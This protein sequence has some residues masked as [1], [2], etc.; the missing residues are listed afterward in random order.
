[1]AEQYVISLNMQ[2]NVAEEMAK[3][4]AQF[5]SFQTEFAAAM[6]EM[7]T[8]AGSLSGGFGKLGEAIAAAFAVEQ[9]VD[10]GKHL[11]EIT[12]TF[13]GFENRIKFSS[14]NAGD[15]AANMDFLKK[16]IDDLH[17]P[18]E[19]TFA[20]FSEM[21]AG[22]RGTGIEGARLRDLFKGLS[23]AST[24]LHLDEYTMQRV[25]QDLRET[26]EIGLNKRIYRSLS[27]TGIGLNGILQQ[28]F[29]KS[30]D[31]L[32]KSGMSGTEFLAKLG[33]ALQKNFA[34]GQANWNQSLQAQMI[35]ARNA[36]TQEQLSM[37]TKLE[38]FFKKA[39]NEITELTHGVGEFTDWLYRNKEAV[40]EVARAAEALAAVWVTYKVAALAASRA[41]AGFKVL[42]NNWEMA[43]FIAAVTTATYLFDKWV[44]K[45]TEVE[46]KLVNIDKLVGEHN[47]M[48]S[49][50]NEIYDEMTQVSSM[51][52]DRL[53][54]ELNKVL[55]EEKKHQDN[56]TYTYTPQIQRVQDTLSSRGYTPFQIQQIGGASSAEQLAAGFAGHIPQNDF[57]SASRL[58]KANKI[59]TDAQA[60]LTNLFRF[61]GTLRAMG[62]KPG[63][64]LPAL[65]GTGLK[66][67]VGKTMKLAGAEGGLGE[68]KSL[69]I[70]FHAPF[71]E[72]KTTD[73]RKLKEYGDEAINGMTRMINN[74]ARTASSG[75]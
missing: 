27:S 5:A 48:T 7:N 34:G 2:G 65:T 19:Q 30:W 41:T 11:M 33:P 55:S 54:Y 74:M 49:S 42:V 13:Q 12:A 37:G 52:P 53:N 45:L 20:G 43:A 68:A 21:E 40:E 69:I 18:M 57:W 8:S 31:E 3:M 64:E 32:E 38:P 46:D 75:Q 71:Q 26:G 47:K 6:E 51:S 36:W 63:E 44:D 72:I 10:F 23:M 66:S 14:L 58:L 24:T 67:T 25:M 62:A 15:A 61:E 50:F 28:Y 22:L 4:Q 70:N 35:D 29:G 1:M 59:M 60:E 39:L 9:V 73:N 16:S 56:I 17:M